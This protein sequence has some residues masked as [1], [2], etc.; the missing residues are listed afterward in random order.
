MKVG[1]QRLIRR[2]FGVVGI[3]Q[4]IRDLALVEWRC[5]E[6]SEHRLQDSLLQ[7]GTVV[8]RQHLEPRQDWVQHGQATVLTCPLAV[9]VVNHNRPSP[10]GLAR[11]A[12]PDHAL[13]RLVPVGRVG[14]ADVVGDRRAE[15][16]N[17]DPTA[18]VHSVHLLIRVRQ[19]IG[20]NDLQGGGVARAILADELRQIEQHPQPLA[21]DHLVGQ[22]EMEHLH[23]RL[24]ARGI[25][26]A[27]RI[28]GIH[29]PAGLDHFGEFVGPD[30]I[31]RLVECG[32]CEEVRLGD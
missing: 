23:H 1:P 21:V 6:G 31:K 3:L 12:V 17:L 22:R 15:T 9:E 27:R 13:G 28:V 25:A 5:D 7:L 26:V 24:R 18:Q 16:V 4:G 8:F 2:D 10:G 32:E 11:H 29:A 19:P 14:P 20:I 30:C